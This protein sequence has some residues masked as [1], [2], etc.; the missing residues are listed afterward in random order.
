M[1]S[2]KMKTKYLRIITGIIFGFITIFFMIN[3]S[4]IHE[5]DT[6]SIL[7]SIIALSFSST[8]ALI[9]TGIAI[10]YRI[11]EGGEGLYFGI[12]SIMVA[13]SVGLVWK[14]YFFKQFSLKLFWD[15]YIF[16]IIVH[17]FILLSQFAFYFPDNIETFKETFVPVILIYPIVETIIGIYIF[18]NKK[19]RDL[20]KE[21]EYN[22][23]RYQTIFDNN[24]I[25]LFQYNNE[26]VIQFVN[27]SF[28]RIM[29]VDKEDLVDF[30]MKKLPNKNLVAELKKSL[31]GESSNYDGFY[32]SYLSK[33]RFYTHVK[34]TPMISD[35]KVVGGIGTMEDLSELIRNQKKIDKLIKIDLLTNLYNRQSFESFSLNKI[36]KKILPITIVAGNINSFSIINEMFSYEEGDKL[37]VILA[38]IFKSF[39][40]KNILAY[41]TNGDEFTLVMN[42]S[43][44][45]D[46]NRIINQL[47]QKIKTISF[48]NINITLSFGL[49]IYNNMNNNIYKTYNEAIINLKSNKVYENS[50]FSKKTIDII[51]TTLFEKS[52]RELKHSQRVSEISALIAKELNLGTAFYN[53]TKLAAKLHDIGKINLDQS[54]LDKP[55]K[56][57]EEEWLKVKKHPEIGFKILSSVRE[58][59]EIASI[60]MSHHERFDGM[61]YP[62]K[63]RENNIPLASRVIAI[64]DSYD[65]MTQ[66]RPYRKTI[67][68]EEAIA[69][70]KRCSGTQFDP[71]VVKIFVENV[72][73]KIQ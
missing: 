36:S 31:E 12:F 29:H 30:D 16:G 3:T 6:K 32:I 54:I 71:N 51:M 62:N 38:K 17:I 52:E 34:F 58:Y 33:H 42:N 72:A 2:N 8:T 21:F 37:L 63:T 18:K 65:A 53:K 4:V 55:G 45:E 10:A 5:F 64:A 46:G 39:T 61:G 47:K 14:K 73:D 25:G 59:L 15:L 56:L 41:R 70:I 48:H 67:T 66:A 50:S 49:A 26:G 13:L 28:A 69:E 1:F 23:K 20:Q 68:K 27:D 35:G 24:P 57:N 7:I 44:L 19:T 60:V 40:N 11:Y 9:T 43:I 22:Q